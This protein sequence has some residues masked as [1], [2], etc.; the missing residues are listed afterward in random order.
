MSGYQVD[1]NGPHEMDSQYLAYLSKQ[2]IDTSV[3][4]IRL[5]D[6]CKIKLGVKLVPF[7][8]MLKMYKLQTTAR[9]QRIDHFLPGVLDHHIKEIIQ[10]TFQKI[11]KP[12]P[13]ISAKEILQKLVQHAKQRCR[14]TILRKHKQKIHLEI[15]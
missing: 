3:E 2:V 1:L 5:L 9:Y 10:S 6:E 8:L 12:M 4:F 13:K 14:E 15:D 11:G 7:S